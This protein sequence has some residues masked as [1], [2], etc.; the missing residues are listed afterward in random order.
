LLF[1]LTLS[2]AMIGCTPGAQSGPTDHPDPWSYT[3]QNLHPDDDKAYQ[4]YRQ[5]LP[6]QQYRVSIEQTC[7]GAP[8]QLDSHDPQS[9]DEREVRRICSD[10]GFSVPYSF[11]F[12][13]PTPTEEPL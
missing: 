2:L 11:D 7:K 6:S 12:D 4:A 5:G 3:R 10:Y 13:T 8:W 1:A 9:V